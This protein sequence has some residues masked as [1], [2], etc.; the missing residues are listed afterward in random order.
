MA[1]LHHGTT[2]FFPTVCCHTY[3]IIMVVLLATTAL[4][5]HYPR[6]AITTHPL[7]TT[8]AFSCTNSCTLIWA[9][10]AA[11]PTLVDFDGAA[12]T[13]I[14][15]KSYDSYG[16]YGGHD[17]SDE[18]LGEEGLGDGDGDGD[19]DL[20]FDLYSLE[21]WRVRVKQ[22]IKWAE[23][24]ANDLPELDLKWCLADWH[25]GR[26]ITDSLYVFSVSPNLPDW[27]LISFCPQGDSRRNMLVVWP[28][29]LVYGYAC[30]CSASPDP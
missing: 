21:V 3:I 11:R 20:D 12:Q 15:Y 27:V 25:D 22:A 13:W 9:G 14:R 8:H 19:E 17:L 4:A 1:R 10:P 7:P 2:S 28:I 5:A 16:S 29:Q 30:T 26:L 6:Y 23:C 18:V 24:I